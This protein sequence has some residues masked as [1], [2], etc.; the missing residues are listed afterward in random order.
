LVAALAILAL[1]VG[2]AACGGSSSSS[3]S[4]TT[5][6]AA[7]STGEESSETSEPSESSASDGVAEAEKLVAAARKPQAFNPPGKPISVSG[8]KGK[9]VYDITNQLAVAFEKTLTSNTT[10]A[11]AKAGIKNVVVQANN[12]VSQATKLIEQ[13]VAQNADA[14]IIESFKS[15]LIAGPLQEA[16]AAG[17]PVIDLFEGDPALPTPKQVEQGVAALATFCYSCAGKL[18]ADWVIADS[19]GEGVHGVT[20]Y[21][22]D[23]GS[24]LAVNE[25]QKAEF[26]KLCPE[27]KVEYKNVQGSQ[28]TTKIPTLTQSDVANPEV[29][30]FIPNFDG[31]A[32]FMVPAIN[33]AGATERVKIASFNANLPFME[34]MQNGGVIKSDVGSPVA[35]MGWAVAD[36][37]MRVMNGEEPLEDVGI[38]LRMFDESNIG[39]IDLS[40]PE[41]AWYGVDFASEYEK[42]WGLK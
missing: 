25:G 33:A 6:E 14:I 23:L 29:N 4:G 32:T 5:S 35:W 17:I 12:E 13:A 41:S 2:V 30:Y 21:S 10:E 16:K 1:G 28:W 42:L 9:T 20:Y 37:T 8:L 27:C 3:S 34:E 38:P 15:D 19:G 39:E 22:D 7:G 18:M 11:L 24:S 31:M 26:A 40:E 36:Q